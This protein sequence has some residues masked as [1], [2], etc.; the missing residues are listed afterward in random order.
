MGA[1][2]KFGLGIVWAILFPLIVA[3][4]AVVMVFGALNFVIQFFIMLFNF[5]RGK[6]LFPVYPEDQKAYDMLKRALDRKNAQEA[7]A[8]TPQQAP[9][10]A[11]YVQQNYYQSQPSPLPPGMQPGMMP[12]QGQPLP[13]GYPQ[14]QLPPGYPQQQQL[15]QGAYP[16]QVPVYPKQ[17][18]MGGPA[19]LPGPEEAMP[20][21]PELARLPEFDM[22]VFDGD[23]DDD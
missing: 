13:P 1:L 18:S 16:Q 23:E 6:K 7:A 14:Q 8:N 20:P 21:R 4:V 5:F 3:A 10:S 11:Y 17:P 19:P 2:K 12:P 15:P 9:M 22:N